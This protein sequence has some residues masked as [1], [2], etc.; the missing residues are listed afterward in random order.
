[1]IAAMATRGWLVGALLL[2][3]AS[4]PERAGPQSLGHGAQVFKGQ[5]ELRIDFEYE[6]FGPRDVS[7]FVQMSE[8]GGEEV[9]DVEIAVDVDGF[10][11]LEGDLRWTANLPANASERHELRLRALAEAR[12]GGFAQ[13]AVQNGPDSAGSYRGGYFQESHDHAGR[14][15]SAQRLLRHY[16]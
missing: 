9:G 16:R 5:G 12:P 15:V 10:N 14:S 2:G 8:L 7:V 3:C 6:A 1:M 4:A 11:V 13:R